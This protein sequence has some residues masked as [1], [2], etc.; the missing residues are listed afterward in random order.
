MAFGANSKVFVSAIVDVLTNTSA[1]DW[2]TDALIK[3][4]LFNDTPTPNQTD[5][6]AHN[7]YA[8]AGGQWASGGVTDTG[9]SAPA[10]WPALGRPMAW[11]TATRLSSNTTNPIKFDSDD[12]V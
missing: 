6:A 2:D 7:A 3:V 11:S 9:S 5:T 8:G 10:G 12:T 4:A 1:T